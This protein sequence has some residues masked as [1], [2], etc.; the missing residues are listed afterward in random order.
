MLENDE[1]YDTDLTE[2]AWALIAP[3]LPA[4]RPRGRP[5]RVESA[6]FSPDGKRVLTS[7]DYTAR[8]WE[9]ETQMIIATGKLLVTFEGHTGRVIKAVFSPDGRRVLTA[10]MD[11]TARLWDAKSGNLVTTFKCHTDWVWSAV[12]SP[13]GRRVL[14]AS[15][16]KT[17]RLWGSR[18]RQAPRH[19]C[20]PHRGR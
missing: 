20:G 16:D 17:A 3:V 1:R 15:E 7:G 5:R 4:Q 13:D 10:S 9:A 11:K 2:E 18:E 6:V 8:L 14:T 12:F 19:V